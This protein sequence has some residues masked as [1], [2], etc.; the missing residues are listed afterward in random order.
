MSA[1]LRRM[2]V[3]GPAGTMYPGS[4][5]DLRS[6]ANRTSFKETGTKWARLWLDWPTMAPKR[7][8]ID[9]T[10]FAALDDQI[11]K[12][13]SDGL[14]IIL[15][16]QRFPGWANGTDALTPQQLAATM[17]DRRSASQS[18]SQAKSLLWRFTDDIS[19]DSDWGR[20][21][22]LLI[23]RYS[24]NSSSRP[25]SGAWIDGLE[26]C[27]E[28]N[29]TWWPQQ[30][31]TTTAD[32]YG[33]GTPV[34]PDVVARMFQTA[35]SIVA[36][37]GGEPLLMG[38]GGG[39][40]PGDSRIRTSYPTLTT[41]LLDALDRLGFVPGVRFVWTVHNYGDVTY[42]EGPGSTYPGVASNP[43]YLVNRTADTRRLLV[44]RWAGWPWG[45][46][47][48]PGLFV[49]EGGVTLQSIAKRWGITDPAQARAKQAELVK[50]N[51]DRMAT[52][53][54][55]GAGV[56]MVASYLFYSDP[57]FDSG[58]RDQFEQGGAKRAAYTT[59]AALP[60]RG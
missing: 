33:P 36:G 10:R 47:A 30:S 59:W 9:A 37:F 29:H 41:G 52:D 44:G 55:D 4:P 24:R 49:T 13:R 7:D 18:D 8:Q 42:D 45:A 35:Q 57:V 51:W 48:N 60:S 46:A 21:V 58:L 5:Q 43:A 38:P 15:T 16:I 56:G 1:Y 6:G 25:R 2:V 23:R 12:A 28:P 54:G 26:L 34:I 3:L 27:E 11:A 20:F 14:R 17:P 53:S 31:P 32:P 50:R 22:R 39:D 19:P 40:D